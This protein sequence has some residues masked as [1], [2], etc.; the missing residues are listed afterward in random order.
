MF[1]LKDTSDNVSNILSKLHIK[2][3]LIF[4]S[5]FCAYTYLFTV[6]L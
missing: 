6:F 2:Q 1:P 4:M 3:L 5:N